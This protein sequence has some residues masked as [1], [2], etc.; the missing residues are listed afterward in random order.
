MSF[1]RETDED[2]AVRLVGARCGYVYWRPRPGVV[3][4]HVTGTDEG[5]FGTQPRDEL[6]EDLRLHAPI[7]L[8][9]ELDDAAGA[10]LPT[11][12]AWSEWYSTHRSAL[13]SVHVLTRTKYMNFTVEVVKLFSR[14][15]DLIRVHVD[16]A[17]FVEE[18]QRAA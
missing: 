8:F 9:I 6:A 5:E 10:R 16:E 13:R 18:L 15:G 2:G 3:V 14:T 7:A 17:P 12:E 1:R 11:Q 4:M